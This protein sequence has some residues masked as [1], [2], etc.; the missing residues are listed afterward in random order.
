MS[1]AARRRSADARRW[2]A[3]G[4]GLPR[5][6]RSATMAAGRS[7]PT[8]RPGRRRCRSR[9]SPPAGRVAAWLDDA[10]RARGCSSGSS[11][12]STASS[13]PTRTPRRAA[14]RGPI[15]PAACPTPTTPPARCWRSRICAVR[16]RLADRRGSATPPKPAS[17]WLLDLQNRDGGMPTFCRGWTGLPFDRSGPELTA[18]AV[19]AWCAWRPHLPAPAA[20]R[21]DAALRRGRPLPVARPARRR[22]LRAAVV[23]QRSGAR[24]GEPDL[25]HRQ[26][27]A[28]PG[29]PGR[30]RRS[31]APRRWPTR[32]ARW[33]AAAQR[34][35]G[36]WSGGVGVD[37]RRRRRSAA[38]DRGDG[39]GG[40]RAGRA[41][42][43]RSRRGPGA[44]PPRP[45]LA[46]RPRPT[47]AATSPPR[48]SA[49][50]SPGSGTARRCIR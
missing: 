42:R 12:S 11:A 28:G 30:R 1:L 6:A 23:R 16:R 44:G 2:C 31:P 10:E 4:V 7:T 20:P 35:D 36:G 21:V 49:S 34:P 27:A 40:G 26:G 47:T 15:S 8:S 19:R 39:A 29:R 24:R 37:V 5:R 18:H 43:P 25:R 45:G 38:V 13:I 50:T 17:R 46:A 41:R 32:A 48:R 14:G 22:R 33:L 9:R 3:H